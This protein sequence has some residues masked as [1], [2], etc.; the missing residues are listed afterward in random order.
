MLDLTEGLCYNYSTSV[1]SFFCKKEPINAVALYIVL[2]FPFC[3]ICSKTV[4]LER[5]CNEGGVSAFEREFHESKV[6]KIFP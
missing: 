2:C 5:F 3:S 6:K 1:G 4:Q